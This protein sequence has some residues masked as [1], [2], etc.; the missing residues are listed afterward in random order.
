MKKLL[1]KKS[2]IVSSQNNNKD[3]QASG[4]VSSSRER[5]LQTQIFKNIFLPF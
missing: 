3:N 1:I 2:H 5:A 4:E